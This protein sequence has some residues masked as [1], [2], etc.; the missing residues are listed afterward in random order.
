MFTT[1]GDRGGWMWDIDPKR[2]Y[3]F[4][5]VVTPGG[6]EAPEASKVQ[7]LM[8]LWGEKATR[9]K[10]QRSKI[11]VEPEDWDEARLRALCA[12]HGWEFEWMT[13]EGFQASARSCLTA[14]FIHFRRKR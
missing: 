12:R 6:D 11:A 1:D 5:A 14:I 3:G 4:L 8:E 10:G 9:A 13:E 7:E 2:R